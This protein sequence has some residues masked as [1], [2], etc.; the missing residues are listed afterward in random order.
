M[1]HTLEET[2]QHDEVETLT[3]DSPYSKVVQID[4]YQETPTVRA[5]IETDN[6]ELHV[7]SNGK[8]AIGH[9]TIPS[10]LGVE[11][12]YFYQGDY[13]VIY[14]H[15]QDKVV[16]KQLPDLVFVQPSE[17]PASF[18]KISFQAMDVFLLTPEYT[19]S[20]GH[21]AYAFGID[22]K[23]GEA[24]AI[25]FKNAARVWETVNY[26]KVSTPVN[27]NEKLVV[28]TRDTRGQG[29]TLTVK[30]RFDRDSK[31]FIAE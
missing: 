15:N 23:S 16:I 25:T 5:G 26:E 3:P 29:D 12:D 30:Y 24:F 1:D 28:T 19:A 21:N 2:S 22:K 17:K 14:E 7:V 9:V 11:G 6:G 27:E 20:R 8:E 4:V 31:Q 18:K 10:V 13:D